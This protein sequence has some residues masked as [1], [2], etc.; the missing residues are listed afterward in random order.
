MEATNNNKN[1]R[2]TVTDFASSTSSNDPN[3][4]VSPGRNPNFKPLALRAR[5][6]TSMDIEDLFVGPRD[7]N[8]HSKWPFFLRLHGSVVP[9]M[10]LPL[11]FVA[12][13]ATMIT[14]ISKFVHPLTFD[15]V[16]LTIT[17]FVVSLALSFRSQTAY[18]RYSDGRKYWAQLMVTG[19]S[20][21][22]IIWIH[23]KERTAEGEAQTKADV[24]AKLTALNLIN[25]YAVSLKH[26]LRFE[27]ATDY[28]DLQPLIG[29]LHTLAGE[30]D[31]TKLLP[32][33]VSSWKATGEY[34]GVTFAHSNPRKLIKR[35]RDNLGNLPLEVL[36]YLGAYLEDI[37]TNGQLT[38]PIHQTNSMNSLV[39]MADILT[40][41]ERVL[42]TPVPLAYS[43]SISQITWVYILVLP[44]QL[45]SKLKWMTI[46]G[47]LLAA[48]IILGLAAIG[49]E[50]ENPFG[51]DVNDLPLDT[52]CRELASDI[53]VMTSIPIP[54]TKN[55]VSVAE[56]KVLYPLSLSDYG[57]WNERSLPEIRAALRAKAT[58]AATS[59]EFERA[60]AQSESTNET[61]E[62]QRA[63]PEKEA[64]TKPRQDIVSGADAV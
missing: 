38:L 11:T 51:D 31:Q 2:L 19:R 60:K 15:S 53:D 57:A 22:R 48:Y 42:N 28:P 56:N 27:P 21:A 5:T 49:Y 64:E 7:M 58:T 3:V 61:L 26:R 35:S 46:F 25:A 41:C 50:I 4:L 17:G 14:C 18:E 1:L 59:V 32:K 34:L 6:H 24:L 10:V 13:W 52:F 36:N 20:L 40:G 54:T 39:Q 33:K 23:T 63:E 47:T 29:N 55:F 8:H 37:C 62:A 30:A 12:G 44:F 43:I 45:Y 16:L 9:K